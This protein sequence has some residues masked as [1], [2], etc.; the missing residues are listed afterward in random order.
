MFKFF[1]NSGLSQLWLIFCF[2]LDIR[3][4]QNLNHQA[5]MARRANLYRLLRIY[6]YSSPYILPHLAA[7]TE[8]TR[9]LEQ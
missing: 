5:K 7:V 6:T 1:N 2:I 9:G 8:C 4:E 3:I